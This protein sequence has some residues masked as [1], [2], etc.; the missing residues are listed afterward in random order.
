MN[1]QQLAAKIW[2]S[3]N[4]MRSKIE[5]SEYKDY[6]LGFIFY[7]FLSEKE[8]E[9]LKKNSFTEEY[10]KK[11]TESDT[12]TVKFCQNNL[13]YFIE[14]K[15]LY[16]T[17]LSDD[18]FDVSNVTTGLSAFSRLISKNYEKVF[19][20]IFNTLEKGIS[21]L[22]DA[23]K[24][25]SK[26]IK[27]LLVL[28]KDI[29]MDDKQGYDVLGFIYEYL[30]GNFAANAGKKAGEFYTPHEVSLLMSEIVANHLQNKNEIRIYDP[31]SGSGSLLINIGKSL[32]KHISDKNGIKY[33]AQEL[34]EPTYNLT[35]MNLVMRGIS[36]S[37][38]V[39]RNG[40]TL[41]DDWP[42]FDDAD[43][44]NTYEVYHLDAVVSNP[45]YSQSW[46]PKNKELD[47]R[48]KE[49]GLAPKG[50]ADYAFLLHDLYHLSPD[51]IMTI[52]LPHGVLFR[53]NEELEIRKQL[54]EKDKIDCVIGL[55]S[56]IFF[57]TG[58]ATII[59]V[60]K[61]RRDNNDVQ[62]IDA[63]K[64]FI[65]EGKNNKLRESDIKKILDAVIMRK[66]I[67]KFSKVVSKEEIRKNNYN[68]NISRYIDNVPVPEKWDIY[69]TMNGGIPNEEIEDLKNYWETL[70]NLKNSLFIPINENY[71]DIA[72]DNISEFLS[73]Y[74]DVL[75]FKKNYYNSFNDLRSYL[76]KELID[77]CENTK[78]TVVESNITNKIFEMAQDIQLVDK[79]DVYQKFMDKWP[80]I[81]GDLETIQ[82]DGICSCKNVVPR[83]VTKKKDDKEEEVQ[84]GWMGQISPFDLIQKLYFNDKLNELNLKQS[85]IDEISENYVEIIN[86]FDEEEADLSVLNDDNTAFVTKNV[87]AKVN[88]IYNSIESEEL[89][90]L[91]DY[92]DLLSSGAKKNEKLDYINSHGTV[93]WDMITSSSDGTYS[94]KNVESYMRTIQENYAFDEESYEY[95]IITTLKLI[96]EES[97]IK[98]EIKLAE[99][100]LLDLTIN[101]VNNLTEEE[102]IEVLENKWIIPIVD[103]IKNLPDLVINKLS[104]SINYLSNK[105]SKTLMNIEKDIKEN[106][107]VLSY[108]IDN[109]N[110]SKYDVLGLEE[111]KNIL[112]GDKYE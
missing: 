6:I 52:V 37:N 73:D 11:L 21:S 46:V 15:N 47:P 22:G 32:S 16:S 44:E 27:E 81:A 64:C 83:M 71:S 77:N 74:P 5:A 56:N 109:L 10:I 12:D 2:K 76:K 18:N 65:K 41:E 105:Y 91:K 94:K 8:I 70:V 100:E 40:D 98:K 35:R 90:I 66:D 49:Y 33:F 86:S 58:I 78:T 104:N 75:E 88:E 51:G 61:H 25:P 92:I 62:I 50:K 57:G 24:T 3:A 39:V 31:T 23:N 34:K 93:N 28:I 112:S 17:W 84:D 89:T 101:K 38:I 1:K 19:K 43:K 29:P 69:A 36:A 68:L 85:R 30:I 54:I 13:G 99:K 106:E 97:S 45:P 7:K 20:G 79:Y 55:P 110:G 80:E 4:K 60:L 67:D 9:F 72:V 111:L 103:E 102:I 95:K 107:S 63:S 87:K 14:Y 82:Q 48:Y 42:Y 26:A 59:M 108:M 53:G 96:E